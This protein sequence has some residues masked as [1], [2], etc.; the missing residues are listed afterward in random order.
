MFLS[1]L[2]EL[3]D[4]FRSSLRNRDRMMFDRDFSKIVIL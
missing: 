1:I 4:Q 2:R 3:L